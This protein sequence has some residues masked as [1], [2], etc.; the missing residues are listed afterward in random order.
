MNRNGVRQ[1]SEPCPAEIGITV[2][3]RPEYA[4]IWQR[5][6]PRSDDLGEGPL[7]MI[8][9]QQHRRLMSEFQEAGNLSDSAMKPLRKS[10][11]WNSVPRWTDSHLL[12]FSKQQ[13]RPRRTCEW[14]SPNPRLRTSK[15]D[16][17]SQNQVAPF[18]Q[19]LWNQKHHFPW[20]NNSLGED[21]GRHVGL[22][23]NLPAL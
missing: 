19:N 20:C 8:T 5:L 11:F 3:H 18:I 22:D 6:W 13:T 7:A 16:Y 14:V 9:K 12:S 1:K 17:A 2:R 23:S 15:S 4:M 10:F 21:L